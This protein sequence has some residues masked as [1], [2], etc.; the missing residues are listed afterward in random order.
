MDEDTTNLRKQAGTEYGVPSKLAGLA[1]L[2]GAGHT[3]GSEKSSS[4]SPI[5]GLRKP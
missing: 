3:T 5:C 4:V 2:H 1:A